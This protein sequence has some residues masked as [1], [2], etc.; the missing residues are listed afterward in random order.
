LDILENH[1][2]EL[3]DFK[4]RYN[5]SINSVDKEKI[6]NFLSDMFKKKTESLVRNMLFCG[7]EFSFRIFIDTANMYETFKRFELV[8]TR[9][10]KGSIREIH[11]K[12][13]ADYRKLGE[14][15]IKIPYE[16]GMYELNDE[17]D[18]YK[19]ELAK[20]THQLIT[21]GNDMGICVGSYGRRAAEGRLII[22][23]MTQNNKYVGCIELTK[24]GKELRQAKAIFNN[25]LQEKKAEALKVWVERKKIETKHCYDYQHI[26]DGEIEYDKDKIYQSTHNYAGYGNYAW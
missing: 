11:D 1:T 16:E 25:V 19:F 22:V 8:D 2:I 20:T 4:D 17:I 14:R 5:N 18:D 6:N 10:L 15:N 24:D 12:M 13:S 7:S 23:T 26:A 3:I 21:V 9:L